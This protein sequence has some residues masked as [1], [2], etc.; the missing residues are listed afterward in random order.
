MSLQF[1]FS[2]DADEVLP[3]TPGELAAT[4]TFSFDVTASVSSV[5]PLHALGQRLVVRCLPSADF[6]VV[7]SIVADFVYPIRDIDQPARL[8]SMLGTFW[9]ETYEGRDAVEVIVGQRAQLEAQAQQNLQE[10][11]DAT[12][13]FKIPVYHRDLWRQ[14]RVLESDLAVNQGPVKYGDGDHYGDSDLNYGQLRANRWFSCELPTDMRA[15]GGIQERIFNPEVTWVSGSDYTI[16]ATELRFNQNPFDAGFEV[17]NVY[18]AGQVTDREVV[19]WLRSVDEDH[20]FIHSH[21]GSVLGLELP[22]SPTYKDLVNAIWDDVVEGGSEMVL[23][24]IVASVTDAP[25]ALEKFEQV[26]VVT[27]DSRYLLIITDKHVYRTS[28]KATAVVTVGQIVCQGDSL[29]DTVEFLDLRSGDTPDDLTAVTIGREMLGED[30]LSGL[31]FQNKLTPLV[32]ATEGSNR[33]A[34]FELQGW[35]LDTERFWASVRTSEAT[36]SQTLAGL[37]TASLGSLPANINPLQ[38]LISNILRNNAFLVRLKS[39]Q[40]GRNRLPLRYLRNL[41]RCVPPHTTVL[42]L[43]DL[44]IGVDTI[45]ANVAGDLTNAGTEDRLKPYMAAVK[46]VETI[47][48]SMVRES[49]HASYV[50]GVCM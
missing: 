9:A 43:I 15:I 1:F 33:L 23:R 13:R 26:Q 22:S 14:L 28:Q 46:S 40:F 37:L 41:R 7:P 17:N 50:T 11:V 2:D 5:I 44:V 20:R 38:F 29:T 8:L 19:I 21:Y 12:S 30:Y 3:G 36:Q 27:T 34:S 4:L 39:Q 49:I 47:S 18:S 25:I 24:R 42:V 31:T 32:V 16:V 48:T 45:T 6:L 10:A 35:P